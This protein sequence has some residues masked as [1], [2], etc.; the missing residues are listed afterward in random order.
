MATVVASLPGLAAYW[1]EIWVVAAMAAAAIGGGA[2][3]PAT[4]T[5]LHAVPGARTE[6]RP[7]TVSCVCSPG[8]VL[9]G[10]FWAGRT[11]VAHFQARGCFCMDAQ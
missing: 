9:T 6:I 3:C 10:V 5:G 1:L 4:G 7:V 2:H 11:H 8:A